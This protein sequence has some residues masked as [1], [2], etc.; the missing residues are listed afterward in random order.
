M[1]KN[2][3][4]V[5]LA[6][7]VLLAGG[8]TTSCDSENSWLS[9]IVNIVQNVLGITGTGTAYTYQGTATMAM[10]N[11]NA[12]NNTYDQDSKYG[13]SITMEASIDVY[14]GDSAVIVKLGDMNFNGTTVADFQFTTYWAEGKIDPEGPSYLTGATCTYNG[15][16]NTEANAAAIMGTYGETSLSLQTIYFQ[17]GDKL[18]MGTFSGTREPESEVE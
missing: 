4:S 2:F 8:V 15:T 6:L 13:I 18:F 5:I 12:S 14:E 3:K 16:A 9:S 7:A 11:Y 17:V 1:K 10:Y